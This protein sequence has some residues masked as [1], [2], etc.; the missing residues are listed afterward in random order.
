[1]FPFIYNTTWITDDKV[2]H[3]II[4]L[5]IFI[6]ILKLLNYKLSFLIVLIIAILKE[7]ID[8]FLENH[9]TELLDIVSTILGPTIIIIVF[10][11][12]KKIKYGSFHNKKKH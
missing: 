3:F 1:M 5:F 6:I 11:I 12:Y 7:I 2:L 4:W 10:F 9:V 8:L